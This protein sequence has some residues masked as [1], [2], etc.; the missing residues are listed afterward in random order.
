MSGNTM[1]HMAAYGGGIYLLLNLFAL[2]VSDILF[3]P[4]KSSYV[5]LPGE[6]RIATADGELINAVFME[7]PQAEYT[8]L[9]SHG[10]AEDLGNVVPF[11]AQFH[12]MGYSI[13]MYDYRGYG[14]SEGRPSYGKSK[15]DADAAYRWLVEEKGI[16]PGRIIA[17]GRSLGG[18]LA[19]WTAAHH[20]VGGLVVES[21]F[22][23]AFRVKTHFPLL[24]WD[25]F[26]SIESIR[27]A[28]CPVLVMHGCEDAII[29]FWHG[30]EL[31]A[32]APE[33]KR[34]LWIEGARHNDYAY[35]AGDRYFEAF[36]SFMELVADH[37]NATCQPIA[38][39][40]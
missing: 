8:I 12:E 20:P 38:M 24:P 23:S 1:M 35:V 17:H 3:V 13:L 27:H 32:A 28:A 4:Q 25:K 29:P 31:F 16:A 6:V 36:R 26:N 7:H 30:K 11:M 22:V 9:F 14:S 34:H 19:V 21:S 39:P 2:L 33:S 18:A 10:N 37:R 5:H 15:K 40:K